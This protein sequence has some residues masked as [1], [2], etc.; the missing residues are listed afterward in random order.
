MEAAHGISKLTALDFECE[1]CARELDALY[2]LSADA[3]K[4]VAK[5]LVLSEVARIAKAELLMQQMLL[6]KWN[7]RQAQA[8]AKAAAATARGGTEAA[9]VAAVDSAMNH[10][11]TD[12]AKP[13]TDGITDIYKLAREAGWK[14]ATGQTKTS[15]QYS[16][17][18]ADKLDAEEA[19]TKAAPAGLLAPS[20]D[21][22]DDSAIMSLH[23]DQMLWVGSHY[24]KDTRDTVR[25][26]VRD[27]MHRGLGR[28][29]AGR[30]MR[31]KIDGALGGRI[32]A[33]TSFRGSS[34]QYF[35]GL[36]ANTATNARVRGQM[37]SF[38]D[39]GVNR[40]ELVNPMDKRTSQICSHLNGKVM[41]VPNGVRQ[42]EGVAGATNPA[43]VKALHPWKSFD[44]VKGISSKAGHVDAKDSGGLAKAGLA[45]PPYHFRCR[46]TIDVTTQGGGS[47]TSLSPAELK[48]VGKP[49]KRSYPQPKGKGKPN[50]KPK[51]KPPPKKGPPA[52]RP[53][54]M[55]T[56]PLSAFPAPPTLKQKTLILNAIARGLNGIKEG[57]K[58][59]HNAMRKGI[60]R[61]FKD[62]YKMTMPVHARTAVHVDP[63]HAGI[64]HMDWWNGEMV[65]VPKF[66]EDAVMGANSAKGGFALGERRSH[67]LGGLFH[68]EIH[69]HS[70]GG[71]AFYRHGLGGK[72]VKDNVRGIEEATTEIL[73]KRITRDLVGEVVAAESAVGSG[74][75]GP[76]VAFGTVLSPQ[77]IKGTKIWKAPGAYRLQ[78]ESVY[79]SVSHN[80]GW[81]ADKVRDAVEVGT[82]KFR[83]GTQAMANTAEEY[84]EN[85]SKAI[86]GLS[87]KQRK[88]VLKDFKEIYGPPQ[89]L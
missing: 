10:W 43:D 75:P 58:S 5:A 36:A 34:K 23:D 67:A 56:K 89:R 44:E 9:I 64:A 37:R 13:F 48:H 76:P 8:T 24:Y 22:L 45:L 79:E 35:E 38:V 65:M 68:E 3:D 41:L 74:A 12:V 87:A 29:E 40:Y 26:A 15:L 70:R 42:I 11:A 6:A 51:A 71:R 80:T 59:G 32:A 28:I 73:S 18:M 7:N 20:F 46:T 31:E 54:T 84:V 81:A 60:Q 88:A 2:I 52:K 86:P 66:A 16:A 63:K 19:V 61:I 39:L 4:L 1:A 25:M 14:K 33:P 78:V 69:N 57:G 83:Q 30:V 53:A 62:K 82:L 17:A 77:N 72:T 85:F 49:I 21:L 27:T 55:P 50:A 47:F